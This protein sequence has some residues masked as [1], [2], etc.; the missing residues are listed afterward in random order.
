MPISNQKY[1][2]VGNGLLVVGSWLLVVG[3][4]VVA[5]RVDAGVGCGV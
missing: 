3:G 4:K 5:V 1:Y 2:I